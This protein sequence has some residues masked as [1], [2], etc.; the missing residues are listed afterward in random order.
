MHTHTHTHTHTHLMYTQFSW[1]D[2]IID[3]V[4]SDEDSELYSKDPELTV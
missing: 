3:R 2:S 1:I 4:A